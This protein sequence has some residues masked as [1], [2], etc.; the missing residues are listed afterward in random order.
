MYPIQSGGEDHSSP[1]LFDLLL[2]I[3]RHEL[4]LDDKGLRWRQHPLAKNL[5]V[6]K[7][8]NVDDWSGAIRSL[9]GRGLDVLRYERPKAVDVDDGAVELI[10][11]AM[12]VTHANFAKVPGMVLVKEDPVMVHTTCVTAAAWMLPVLPNASM[13][14]AH[15]PSLLPVLLKAGRHCCTSALC[16]SALGFGAPNPAAVAR[17]SRTIP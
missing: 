15:V 8:G 11:K 13:A 12:E 5:E 2:G 16:V 17:N 4:S 10:T 14:G 1:I 6:P 7:L 3:L 9:R